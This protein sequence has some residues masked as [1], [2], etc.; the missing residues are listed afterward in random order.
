MPT[1]S[2]NT[3]KRTPKFERNQMVKGRS[4]FW[5][6]PI[7]RLAVIA[8]AWSLTTVSP[9]AQTTAIEEARFVQLGGIEQWVTLRGASRSSP[10]LVVLHGGPGEAQSP[11]TSTWEPLERDFVVVQWDQRGGGRTLARA[12]AGGQATSLELLTQ[13]GIELAQYVRNHLRTDRVILLGHSWGSFL[14]VHIV[15]RQPQLFR[16]FVGTGQVTTWRGM[17]ESQYAYALS[18]ARSE[19][20]AAAVAELE[21]L[22]IPASDNFDQYLVMRR[23]LNRYLATSDLQW[24][25]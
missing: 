9:R 23:W 3:P 17:V 13:D 20:N 6:R 8:V 21:S 14:G 22:G 15:K 18:R 24:I 2:L 19:S 16:A 11:L 1:T 5:F 7:L 10:V 25:P 4:A 12:G